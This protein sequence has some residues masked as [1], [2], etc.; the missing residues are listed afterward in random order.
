MALC[1]SATGVCYISPAR[2]KLS[3]GAPTHRLTCLSLVHI[4]CWYP[5]CLNS[6]AKL[7]VGGM[8]RLEEENIRQA[9]QDANLREQ[10]QADRD[11]IRQVLICLPVM[12]L[13]S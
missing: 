6:K 5:L 3:M 12:F 2:L 7:C 4:S 13:L 9:M 1:L 11:Q 8:H 10:A